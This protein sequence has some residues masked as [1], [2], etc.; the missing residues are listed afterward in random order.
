MDLE[1]NEAKDEKI[2]IKFLILE[3]RNVIINFV[4]P[5]LHRTEVSA[6]A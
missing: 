5:N 2:F 3:K 4:E 6:H 1:K